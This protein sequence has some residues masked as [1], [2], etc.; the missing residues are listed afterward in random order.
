MYVIHVCL[1]STQIKDTIWHEIIYGA[2]SW[3]PGVLGSLNQ[4]VDILILLTIPALLSLPM[5]IGVI[6]TN[7]TPVWCCQPFPLSGKTL[8]V[9]QERGVTKWE[10]NNTHRQDQCSLAH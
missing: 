2:S 4:S 6:C 7:H 10:P 5:P 1:S 9:I 3:N 8:K